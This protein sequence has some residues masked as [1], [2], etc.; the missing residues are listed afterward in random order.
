MFCTNCGNQLEDGAKFCPNCGAKVS[1]DGAGGNA[2]QTSA[3][4]KIKWREF[5][6]LE[7]IERSVAERFGAFEL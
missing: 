7:N 2:D 3:E 4:E 6:T 1:Q 5:L